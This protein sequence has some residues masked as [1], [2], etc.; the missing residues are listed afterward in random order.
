MP[1]IAPNADRTF[2]PADADE[3]KPEG[4]VPEEDVREMPTDPPEVVPSAASE[5]T[6]IAAGTGLAGFA[7]A[8]PQ[9]GLT[10]SDEETWEVDSS[11]TVRL[12]EDDR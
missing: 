6:V 2:G 9:G 10:G 7:K 3:P 12:P 11:G 5:Q 4:P 8:D 1:D